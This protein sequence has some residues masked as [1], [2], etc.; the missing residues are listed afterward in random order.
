MMLR[1]FWAAF[2]DALAIIVPQRGVIGFASCTAFCFESLSEPKS[3]TESD[4]D[5]AC[6]AMSSVTGTDGAKKAGNIVAHA[7]AKIE[8]DEERDR[9]DDNRRNVRFGL[10]VLLI[11]A[12]FSH[13]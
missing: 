2:F 5:G 8:N 4:D 10:F 6:A 1:S 11:N 13:S 3:S 9:H 7:L 12:A